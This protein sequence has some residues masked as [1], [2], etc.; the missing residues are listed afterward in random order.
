[1]ESNLPPPPLVAGQVDVG[2]PGEMEEAMN[3]PARFIGL[4]DEWCREHPEK[5][6]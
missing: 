3:D 5:G 6:E 2:V 4:A 1:M